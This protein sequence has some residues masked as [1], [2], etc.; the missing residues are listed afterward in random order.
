MSLREKTLDAFKVRL[1]AGRPGFEARQPQLDISLTIADGVEAEKNVIIEAGTG[2]GKSYGYLV[3]AMEW[4][5]ENPSK[6]VFVATFAKVLQDQIVAHDIPLL[7][8]VLGHE[9]LN[10]VVLKGKSNYVCVKRFNELRG[11]LERM[12]PF[13]ADAKGLPTIERWR[14]WLETTDTGDYAEIDNNSMW[15]QVNVDDDCEGRDCKLVDECFYFKMKNQAEQADILIGNHALLCL[16][17]AIRASSD[18]KAT[19]VPNYDRVIVDEAHHLEDV[20]TDAWTAQV[21]ETRI[22]RIINSINAQMPFIQIGRLAEQNVELFQWF[23]DRRPRPKTPQHR[24]ETTWTLREKPDDLAAALFHNLAS[25]KMQIRKHTDNETPEGRVAQRLVNR[26]SM[27]YDDLVGIL[28]L[29][30]EANYSHW[31]ELS[32]DGMSVTLKCTPLSVAPILRKFLFEKIPTTLASATISV[33]KK[34]DYIK[35]ALGIDEAFTSI[36][37]SPFDYKNNCLMYIPSDLPDPTPANQPESEYFRKYTMEVRRLIEASQGGVL[38]LFTS[39]GSLKIV[40]DQMFGVG[41]GSF[42]HDVFYHDQINGKRYRVLKQGEGSVQQ[43]ID[44]F[45]KDGNA[46]LFGVASFWE[47]L[48]V[49]GNALRCVV[50]EKMPFEVPTHP[51]IQAKMAALEPKAFTAFSVPRA[52]VKFKQGFGRLIRTS[53]D[54]GVVAIMDVRT[55]NKGYGATFL[56]SLPDCLRTR[57]FEIVRKFFKEESLQ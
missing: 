1:P 10:A 29:K 18:D 39:W 48:D 46:I 33:A 32:P 13:I 25:I 35:G 12:D 23:W 34:F 42:G 53:F 55:I 14:K 41:A 5:A 7:K 24:E 6:R 49:P 11:Q 20:A 54:R 21:T 30:D 16:D 17:L 19:I 56:N 26:I 45:K 52:V 50:I 28:D 44:E 36:V 37:G 57:N 47:G 8:R 40:Y 27:V 51:V 38:L 2:T 3:P 22:R 4:V 15:G 43:N 9:D 31:A